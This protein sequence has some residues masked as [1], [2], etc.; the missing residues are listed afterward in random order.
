MINRFLVL[1]TI[2]LLG[3]GTSFAQ[4]SETPSDPTQFHLFLLAGQSNMAGRGKVSSSDK[5]VT[6]RVLT[7][8]QQD[9]WVAAVDPIHFDKPAIN[10]IKNKVGDILLEQRTLP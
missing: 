6:P 8:D 9:K 1:F 4:Q 2:C 3:S 10:F 7:L 5:K